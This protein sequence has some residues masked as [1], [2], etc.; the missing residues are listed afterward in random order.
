MSNGGGEPGW[1]WLGLLKW[2][3]NYSDGTSNETPTPMSDED[4]AF[5]ESV[6]KDGI[7][8][9]GE[10]MKFI[11]KQVTDALELWKLKCEGQELKEEPDLEEIESLLLELRDIVEQ[12]DYAR[13]F[14]SMK[15]LPFLLG[16]AQE[17]DAVPRSVRTACLGIVATMCQ[18]N[19]PVQLDLLHQGSIKILSELY[20]KEQEAGEETAAEIQAK[21]IQAM[22]AN[23][24]NHAMGEEVFCQVELARQVLAS[25]LQADGVALRKRALFFLRALVTS[26]NATRERVRLFNSSLAYIADHLLNDETESNF[27]IR[28]MS[29]EL[30]SQI[31]EQRKSVNAVLSRKDSLAALGVR[32]ISVLRALEGE[33]RE[34]A[35]VELEYWETLLRLIARAVPDGD[36]QAPLMLEDRK[37]QDT[38]TV[39]Q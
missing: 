7:V 14:S 26:D 3:L 11:L 33:E 27:E 17:R 4:K 13:A 39:P 1:A 22:S 37:P 21:I 12:I 6:M 28:E 24:R 5:L 30:L 8:N 15:G 38:E 25:A 32:R 9:E 36:D 18:N 29:L 19:P 10:R 35:A 16:C 23:V 34:Y 20:R 2:S 31:L